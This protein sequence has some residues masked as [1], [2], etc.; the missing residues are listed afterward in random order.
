MQAPH[1]SQALV[2]NLVIDYLAGVAISSLIYG[3]LSDRFGRRHIILMAL[4]IC[5]I[6]NAC[7][8]F[9]QTGNQLLRIRLLAGL[10]AGGCLTMARAIL[11]DKFINKNQIT[12]ALSYFAMSSSLSPAFAPILGGFIQTMFCWQINFLA[13][14][15]LGVTVLVLTYY[16]SFFMA[17]ACGVFKLFGF[18]S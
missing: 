10:G 4:S 1:T 17:I 11:R 9:A 5:I 16:L 15:L 3:P 8:I 18:F 14:M 6:G 13:F 12:R 2:K 7:S